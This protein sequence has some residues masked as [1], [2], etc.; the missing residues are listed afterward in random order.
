MDVHEK[1][2]ADIFLLHG[3]RFETAER[4]GG[5]TNAVWLNGDLALRL[6]TAINGDRLRREAE[7]T[8]Y[9]PPGAGYPPV[10]STGVTDG[11]EWCVSKRVDGIVLSG[12]WDGF[13]YDERLAALKQITGIMNCVH[14]VDVE[15]I[16]AIT[17]RSAW[18][19]KFDRDESLARFKSYAADKIFTEAQSRA[20]TGVLEKFY[21]SL[22]GAR[23]VMN[24]GDIT[25]D[26][27]MWRDGNV[28]ALLDYEHSVVA[29]PLL[30]I[31]SIINM[32]LIRGGN[33]NAG[34]DNPSGAPRLDAGIENL[35]KPYITSRTDFDLIVGYS[36]LFRQKF[37]E[38][39]LEKPDCE[40]GEA[41]FYI[42]LISLCDGKGGFLS[43]LA[44]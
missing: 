2:A 29:P 30:D 7:R 6:S 4:A 38:F 27:L 12:V 25:T 15:K 19:C 33:K 24:H 37:L 26:N 31:Q 3:L 35:I 13:N 40:L 28:V 11:Y 43:G 44:S 14:S 20:F 42:E 10:I 8:K 17:L 1:I 36:V 21:N 18:Y 39:W 9:L 23:F 5:W 22:D 41:D 16:D 32:S 34:G